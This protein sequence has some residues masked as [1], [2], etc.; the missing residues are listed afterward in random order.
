MLSKIVLF[1]GAVLATI[2]GLAEASG[3]RGQST[4]GGDPNPK[5]P[6]NTF[7]ECK[8]GFYGTLGNY[9]GSPCKNSATCT[10]LPDYDFRCNCV[11]GWM[12]KLCE[13]EDKVGKLNQKVANL[14]HEIRTNLKGE[15]G[16]T[17]AKGDQGNTGEAGPADGP[18]GKT[19]KT[20]KTGPKG[21]KGV[22]RL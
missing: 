3:I 17:G 20:G 9:K 18:R 7:D 19:G 10:D 1:T 22:F 4:F 8:G 11:V 12:G 2:D 13:E 14:E 15:K 6:H 16:D 21:H 5:D